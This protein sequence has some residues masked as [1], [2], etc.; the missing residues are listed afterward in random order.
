MGAA[1]PCKANAR[2]ASLGT[3]FSAMGAIPVPPKGGFHCLELLQRA[4]LLASEP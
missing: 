2:S 4:Q 1:N 3:L